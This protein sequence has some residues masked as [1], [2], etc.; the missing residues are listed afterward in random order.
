MLP[1]MVAARPILNVLRSRSYAA[2]PWRT[3]ALATLL[4]AL[5]YTHGVSAESAAGHAHPGASSSVTMTTHD[6]IAVEHSH[7]GV[8]SHSGQRHAD[9]DDAPASEHAAHEC[10]S[11][12]P[13]QGTELPTPCEVPMIRTPHAS[14]PIDGRPAALPWASPP[15][16]D[17]AILRI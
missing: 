10:V 16:P 12:Q 8:G 1:A 5:F 4:L 17:S 3:W 11:G 14:V 7:D 6:A 2:G 13:E 9:Q 15:L